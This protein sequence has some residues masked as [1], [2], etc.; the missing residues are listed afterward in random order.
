[1]SQPLD[2][3]LYTATIRSVELRRP[4]GPVFIAAYQSE[5]GAAP[6][7]THRGPELVPERR[8]GT[9]VATDV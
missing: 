8:R 6:D 2:L 4:G 9:N 1:M 3:M 5:D 7:E